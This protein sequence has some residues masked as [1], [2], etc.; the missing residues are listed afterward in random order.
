VEKNQSNPKPPASIEGL[1][2]NESKG[3]GKSQGSPRGS[4]QSMGDPK[5]DNRSFWGLGFLV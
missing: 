5:A 3:Q 1:A 2:D 4:N